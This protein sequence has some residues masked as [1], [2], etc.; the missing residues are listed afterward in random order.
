[1]PHSLEQ[2]LEQVARRGSW[3]GGGSAAALTAA[4]SAA[5]LEKVVTRP[6][7]AQRLR[8]RRQVCTQ[9]I[10]RDA[11]MFARVIEATRTSNPRAVQ[12][13]L[14]AAT[15][16]PCRVF[17]HAQAVQQACRAA[18]RSVKPQLQSDLRCALALAEAAG[19][20]ARV[21]IQTNLA[22]LKD[23]AYAR[24]VRRRLH[25]MAQGHVR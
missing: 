10:H 1:M 3:L 15:D 7:L 18:R 12:R 4:L 8:R 13:R 5:L 22:W 20:S 21:L 24:R 19:A 25:S 9:L 23:A 11:R 16:V 2:L 14:K 17:E 6:R